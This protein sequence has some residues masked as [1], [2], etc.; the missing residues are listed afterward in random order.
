VAKKLENGNGKGCGKTKEDHRGEGE[1]L[2]W[3]QEKENRGIMDGIQTA[4]C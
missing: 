1:W 4:Q 2:T 3:E